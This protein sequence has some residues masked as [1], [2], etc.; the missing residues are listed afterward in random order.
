M[1]KPGCRDGRFR[2][3][4]QRRQPETRKLADRSDWFLL[5]DLPTTTQDRYAA[6]QIMFEDNFSDASARAA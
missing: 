2:V 1:K 5:I 3:R 4:I 6:T